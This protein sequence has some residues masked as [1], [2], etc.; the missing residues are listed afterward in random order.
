E[1]SEQGGGAMAF[2]VVG[3]RLTAA[4]FQRQARLSPV[5][6]LNLGLLV[7]RQ[8]ERMLRRVEVQ[9]NDIRQFF[10]KAGVVAQ[11]ERPDPMGLEAVF[12]PDTAHGALAHPAHPSHAACAPL[13]GLGR[14]LLGGLADDLL[15]RFRRYRRVAPGTRGI[16]FD[17]RDSLLNKAQAPPRDG[18]W[19]RSQRPGNLLVLL[20]VR[21]QQQDLGPLAHTQWNLSPARVAGQLHTLWFA[22]NDRGSNP[23]AVASNHTIRVAPLPYLNYDATTPESLRGRPSSPQPGYSNGRPTCSASSC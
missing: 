11:L 8:H 17:A 21:S 3:H 9:T 12:S 5:E 23:H 20:P 10:G 15:D 2:V 22:E 7:Q 1:R 6:C 19:A 14:P 4:L 18:R 13:G 16:G